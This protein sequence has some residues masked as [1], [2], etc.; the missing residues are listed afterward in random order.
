MHSRF[1]VNQAGQPSPAAITMKPKPSVIPTI[2]GIVRRKPKFAPEAVTKTTFGPGVRV[3]TAANR[4][5]G[6]NKIPSPISKLPL[7]AK[8][9]SRQ[10]ARRRFR[11]NYVR[12]TRDK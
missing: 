7:S 10:D 9:E 3:M 11:G 4:T 2:C 1:G 12:G 6:P 8:H 5:K